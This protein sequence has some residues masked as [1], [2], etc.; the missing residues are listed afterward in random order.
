[1]SKLQQ[2]HSYKAWLSDLKQQFRSSQLKA[3]IKVNS[4][5]L[6]FYWFLGGNILERQKTA[7]WGDAFL[8]QLSKDLM[9]EFPEVKGFS[10]R[11]LELIRQW[12][13]YW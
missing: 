12:R 7:Q 5:L 13:N 11:N 9:S 3:V 8:S 6:H 2:D 1:M 4:E 10:K